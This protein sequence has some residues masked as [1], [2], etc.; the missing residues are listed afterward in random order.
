[1]KETVAGN[2]SQ[3]YNLRPLRLCSYQYNFCLSYWSRLGKLKCLKYFFFRAGICSI[4]CTLIAYQLCWGTGSTLCF[5]HIWPL[6]FWFGPWDVIWFS[7]LKKW[8]QVK[9][10]CGSISGLISCGA[11]KRGKLQLFFHVRFRYK[12]TIHPHGILGYLFSD[13]F[14][15]SFH[16]VVLHWQHWVH[17][18][19]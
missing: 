14:Q 1:M 18:I 17:G 15:A 3:R 16:K 13:A 2:F 8:R 5:A 12:L 11:E 9:L 6:C 7:M 10:P 4:G 19:Q